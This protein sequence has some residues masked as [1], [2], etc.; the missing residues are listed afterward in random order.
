MAPEKEVTWEKIINKK[1][2]HPDIR[3]PPV[4]GTD[5]LGDETVVTVRTI[6]DYPTST[7]QTIAV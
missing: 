2:E 6:H 1:E 7:S 5:R 3:G 4:R